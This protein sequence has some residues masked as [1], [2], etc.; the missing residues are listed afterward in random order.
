M[1][2]DRS[3]K[4]DDINRE[5]LIEFVFA[6]QVPDGRSRPGDMVDVSQPYLELRD[7]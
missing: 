7:I 2:N 1:V 6:A 3:E 5:K 4:L